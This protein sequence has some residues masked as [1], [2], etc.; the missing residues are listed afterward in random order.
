M[1]G[2]RV[3]EHVPDPSLTQSCAE[4]PLVSTMH[5]RTA[6]MTPITRS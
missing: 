4:P 6:Q 5:G 1:A 2:G 3:R